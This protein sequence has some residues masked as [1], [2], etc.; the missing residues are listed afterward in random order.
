MAEHTYERGGLHYTLKSTEENGQF[1]VE[2]TCH[3]CNR[4]FQ[5]ETFS[6]SEPEAIGRTQAKIFADHH[7][8][9]H[10]LTRRGAGKREK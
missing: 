3:A 1:T 6:A 10:V 9:V 5:G 2:W 8:P 4:T 7:V